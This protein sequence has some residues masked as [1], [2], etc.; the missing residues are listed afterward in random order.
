[1]DRDNAGAV[2]LDAGFSNLNPFEEVSASIA[3]R[4][5]GMGHWFFR[6]GHKFH[7]PRLQVQ[8][9]VILLGVAG[10][11]ALL[12][13]VHVDVVR[14]PLPDAFGLVNRVGRLPEIGVVKHRPYNLAHDVQGRQPESFAG[15]LLSAFLAFL[16]LGRRQCENF[17]KLPE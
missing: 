15:F 6:F 3:F 16:P 10:T 7:L 17:R 4:P 5:C 9:K 1:M 8:G 12:Q 2:N 13:V 11:L 14:V